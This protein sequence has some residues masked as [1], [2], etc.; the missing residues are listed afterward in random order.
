MRTRGTAKAA[1]F[2]CARSGRRTNRRGKRSDNG[3]RLW[4][5]LIQL[6]TLEIAT[7]RIAFIHPFLYRYARGIERF[8]FRLAN[9]LARDGVEVE[10]LTWSWPKPVA[11]DTLEPQVR[12]RVLPT[13]RYF[14]A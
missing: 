3:R 12:V 9:A 13:S 4:N 5:V 10:I 14:A 1:G 7:M 6:R 11:I 2:S 8:L